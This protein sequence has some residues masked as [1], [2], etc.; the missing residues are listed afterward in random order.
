ML[1]QPRM[2]SETQLHTRPQRYVYHIISAITDYRSI[3]L[4]R[5]FMLLG[6]QIDFLAATLQSFVLATSQNY[7]QVLVKLM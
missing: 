1:K 4:I 6:L 5:T 3:E 7:M 2:A